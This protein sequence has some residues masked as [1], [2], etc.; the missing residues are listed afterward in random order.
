MLLFF[1]CHCSVN[2]F[3]SESIIYT[4][5]QA[6]CGSFIFAVILFSEFIFQHVRK[7]LLQV[8]FSVD[9]CICYKYDN[10]KLV[11]T[12]LKKTK[13]KKR[14]ANTISNFSSL[15]CVLNNRRL[16]IFLVPKSAFQISKWKYALLTS[17]Q[18][19]FTTVKK[20]LFVSSIRLLILSLNFSPKE[21]H[22]KVVFFNTFQ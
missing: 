3:V 14:I 22:N 18:L 2:F 21:I 6:W 11:F 9:I 19:H 15:H 17:L 1:Y 12:A 16:S 5:L 20:W 13:T 7:Y 4:L 10:H 8:A